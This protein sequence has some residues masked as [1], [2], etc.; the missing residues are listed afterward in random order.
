MI[1]GI[2]KKEILYFLLLSFFIG[3]IVSVPWAFTILSGGEDFLLGCNYEGD[4]TDTSTY[5]SRMNSISNGILFEASTYSY[6]E[7]EPSG[8][9][10]LP[11]SGMGELFAGIMLSFIGRMLFPVLFFFI[12]SFVAFLSILFLIRFLYK[13]PVGTEYIFASALIFLLSQ[14]IMSFAL[15][16]FGGSGFTFPTFICFNHLLSIR[17]LPILSLAALIWLSNKK[18]AGFIEI[19]SCGVLFGLVAYSYIYY[20]LFFYLFLFL[21]FVL[22]WFSSK[23]MNKAI[24]YSAVISGLIALPAFF[25][26]FL[27]NTA[28]LTP[29]YVMS[30][31]GGAIIY[32]PTITHTLIFLLLISLPIFALSWIRKDK[33]NFIVLSAV[34]LVLLILH[35][36][37]IISG[38]IAQ[39]DHFTWSI[40]MPILFSVFSIVIFK[41]LKRSRE[42][43][44]R[45]FVF[46]AIGISLLFIFLGLFSSVDGIKNDHV[47]DDSPTLNQLIVWL[48]QNTEKNSV[49]LSDPA[50]THLISMHTHNRVYYAPSHKSFDYGTE[51]EFMKRYCF[52][53]ETLN[54]SLDY[55]IRKSSLLYG[56]FSFLR[57][58]RGI[59]ASTEKIEVNCS[60]FEGGE[61]Y[62][63]NYIILSKDS[64]EELSEV[65]KNKTNQIQKINSYVI[66][67]VF[68]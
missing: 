17:W 53:L 27:F 9:F 22:D 52:E 10:Y 1:F 61:F 68:D 24:F 37:Q 43:L 19:V 21:F 15:N 12:F 65:Q 46:V 47:C 20:I 7:M 6:E 63:Y 50:L 29:D 64:G 45:N 66:Y 38:K 60:Q 54:I 58:L 56:G 3:I 23:K 2:E 36:Q 67:K 49:I 8:F 26:L 40:G 33:M 42:I 35:N 41:E 57:F 39:T 14:A 18:D 32:E 13:K 62:R 34:F 31:A 51:D 5:I 16:F 11:S 25:N 44:C 30:I 4:L 48:N 59:D 28:P 55:T